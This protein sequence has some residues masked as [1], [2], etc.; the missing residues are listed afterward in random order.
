ML[1]GRMVYIPD[2]NIMG[3]IVKEELHGAHVKYYK[4]GFEV[5][6]YL[7]ADDYEY[8]EEGE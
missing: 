3:E 8:L 6:E 5:T 7:T 4:G 1:N 2:E